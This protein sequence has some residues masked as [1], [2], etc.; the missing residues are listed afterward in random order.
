V[1]RFDFRAKIQRNYFVGILSILGFAV[2]LLA[3]IFIQQTYGAGIILRW[4]GIPIS[5]SV[6]T[7]TPRVGAAIDIPKSDGVKVS[8][9][10]LA[11][12]SNMS[13][14]GT[15]LLAE[16]HDPR[17]VVF[18]NDYHWH[19]ASE[20]VDDPFNQVDIVSEDIDA[21]Y[22]PSKAFADALVQRNPKLRIGLIPCAKGAS[23]IAE[24]Q[25]N[26]SDQALYGSCLKRARAASTIGQLAGLLVFQG[27]ADAMDAI[28]FPEHEVNPT[29]WSALFSAFVN[30]FRLDLSEPD[31]PVVYA[32]IGTNT[33]PAA[34]PNWDTVKEQQ[35]ITQLPAS[36]MIT[37]D[38]LPLMDNVHFTS[39]SYRLIGTRFAEAYWE[40]VR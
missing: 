5:T 24:W 1:N 6:P 37:T 26:L 38:D 11:G 40:L 19:V 12:Q 21:G 29:R 31:L 35:R 28:Q 14:R 33:T 18:G 36:A 10:I 20:P 16:P 39:E 3:G 34:F 17:I 7:P 27:E 30:D 13:G 22:S 25:R 15:V 9:F 32:Q 2:G 4:W 8:L 23:S